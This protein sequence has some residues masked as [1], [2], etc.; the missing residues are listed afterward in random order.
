MSRLEF[1]SLPDLFFWRC[2]QHPSKVAMEVKREGAY[3]PITWEQFRND[4][5]RAVSLLSQFVPSGSRVVHVSENRYDWLVTDLAILSLGAIHVPLHASLTL[6][7]QFNQAQDADSCCIIRSNK[8]GLQLPGLPCLSYD[9]SPTDGAMS[10]RDELS[11]ADL[12]IGQQ[13]VEQAI[14]NIRPDA[15]ATILYTSGTTGE[16]KGVILTHGN[17]LANAIRAYEVFGIAADKKRFNF[18]PYSHIFARTCDFYSWIA[19][20]YQLVLA[21]SK[22]TAIVDCQATS[23]HIVTAV[24]YFFD[25]VYRGLLV[26]GVADAP[27]ILKKTLG[28]QFEMGVCGGAPLAMDTLDYYVS[29]GVQL[30]EGYG[31]TETSPVLTTNTPTRYRRG[32]VGPALP[33]VDLRIAEDGEICARGPSVFQGY[34]KKLDATQEVIRDGWFYTGDIGRLDDDGFLWITGRKKEL[35]VTAAGKKIAPTFVESLLN[36]DPLISQS[37]VYGD[38]EKYLVALIVPNLEQLMNLLQNFGL[39]ETDICE[40]ILNHRVLEAYQKAVE[41]RLAEL[42]HYE[43]VQSFSLLLQPFSVETG[44]LTGKLSMRRSVIAEKYAAVI[45]SLYQ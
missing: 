32:S 22:D 23:P 9:P 39:V 30:L 5:L 3:Q 43:Q 11:K 35:I 14:A 20:G 8:E 36:Q 44:E 40:A 25:K 10:W 34:W 18:L 6:T 26:A 4:V 29:Q 1:S 38:R 2:H 19:G 42:S 37:F 45:R 41:Q 21:E 27:G 15:I 7:Q 28:G 17:L 16:S 12:A 31:L 13:I 33:E 24:P